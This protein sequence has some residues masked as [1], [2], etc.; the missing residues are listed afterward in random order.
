MN[1]YDQ[2]GELDRQWYLR[3][4]NQAIKAKLPELITQEAVMG[5]APDQRIR[6]AVRKL[7]EPDFRYQPPT[8]QGQGKGTGP[9]NDGGEDVVWIE[10]TTEEIMDLLLDDLKL[11]RLEDKP[12]GVLHG[13]EDRY[14]DVTTH[15][16][17]ANIDKRRLG[18]IA[19]RL[20]H[21]PRGIT[22]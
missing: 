11:P 19:L 6:I 9:G 10:L 20:I 22:H 4:L 18:Q 15:G 17:W 13:E 7:E 14:D 8:G 5:S 2:K 1:L 21:R 12:R 16:P 3:K